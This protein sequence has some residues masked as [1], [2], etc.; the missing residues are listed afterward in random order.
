MPPFYLAFT[1]V[2]LI[3]LS[4]VAHIAWS[5]RKKLTMLGDAQENLRTDYL[6]RIIRVE[7]GNTSRDVA[8]SSLSIAVGTLDR[9]TKATANPADVT[10]I[11]LFETITPSRELRES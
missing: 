4:V 10:S 3:G 8:I 6:D 7:T 1:I 5:M 2:L 11:Q 9:R